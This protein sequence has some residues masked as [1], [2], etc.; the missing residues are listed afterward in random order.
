[1]TCGSCSS[2]GGLR[3]MPV[4]GSWKMNGC[5]WQSALLF[6][7]NARFRSFFCSH[8]SIHAVAGSL[9]DL[10]LRF[11]LP[12]YADLFSVFFGSGGDAWSSSRWLAGIEAPGPLPTL[13]RD[14][15]RSSSENIARLRCDV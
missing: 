3:P 12:I 7:F 15:P 13:G 4:I 11:R 8:L 10:R 14:R 2:Q 1:M 6:C 9:L 5:V